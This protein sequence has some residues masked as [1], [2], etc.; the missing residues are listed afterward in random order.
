MSNFALMIPTEL[1]PAD[2][3]RLNAALSALGAVFGPIT[4]AA[5]AARLSHPTTATEP[6]PDRETRLNAALSALTDTFG[7]MTVAARAA[8]LSHPATIAAA[9]AHTREIPA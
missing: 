4:V 8:R 5:R 2:T 1:H 3:I 6:V 7:P 9:A